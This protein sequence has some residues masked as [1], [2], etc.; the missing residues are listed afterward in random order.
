MY[1]GHVVEL[2]DTESLYAR[3]SHPY[4]QALISAIPQPDPALRRERIVLTGDMPSPEAPPPGCVFHPRCPLAMEVCTREMPPF[5]E[6]GTP[7][8]PHEV[9][10][11]RYQPAYRDAPLPPRDVPGRAVGQGA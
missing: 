3:P 9:R 7:D 10:C 11:H 6:I 8:R 2:T 4:T 5:A 1:L